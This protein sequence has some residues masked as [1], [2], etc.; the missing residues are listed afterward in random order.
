MVNKVYLRQTFDRALD[1]KYFGKLVLEDDD[2]R[3][4]SVIDILDCEQAISD[5]NLDRF[6]VSRKARTG[7]I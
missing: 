3:Y 7:W 1:P 2:F 6:K 4:D 5:A